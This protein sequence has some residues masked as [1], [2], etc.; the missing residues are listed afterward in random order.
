MKTN[1][2]TVELDEPDEDFLRD[3]NYAMVGNIITKITCE[4]HDVIKIHT[5]Q[6]QVILDIAAVLYDGVP[7]IGAKLDI[8]KS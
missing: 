7:A 4:S 2:P 8:V 5:A 6:G 1:E 3:L